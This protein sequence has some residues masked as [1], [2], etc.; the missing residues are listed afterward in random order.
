M[1]EQIRN[2]QG[3]L[4]VIIG[5]GML[6]FL[7]PYDAVLA[8]MGQDKKVVDGK[9]RFI[10]AREIGQTFVTADVPAQDVLS[11]LKEALKAR[12]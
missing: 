9:L 2:R 3:L 5:I 11:V 6:G 12:S 4:L 8:L 10:M 7:V 1:I